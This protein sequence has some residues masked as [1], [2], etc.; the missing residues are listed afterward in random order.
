[1]HARVSRVLL[2]FG[3]VALVST[4]A[5][6]MDWYKSFENKRTGPG[7][8][9][10]DYIQSKYSKILVELDIVGDATPHATALSEFKVEM[11]RALGKAITVQTSQAESGKGAGQAYS[12]A[13]IRA[14][15]DKHRNHFTGDDTAVMYM[16]YLD[17]TNSE[18]G[19]TLGAAYQGSSV[20]MFKGKMKSIT[21]TGGLVATKPDIR[22]VERGVLVHEFGHILGL[23][24][25]GTPMVNGHEDP[26]HPGH[27]NNRNSVMFWAVETGDITQIFTRGSDI[28]Y[29][30]DANDL[31]DIRE[32]RK[33]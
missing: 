18:N 31:A 32:Y 2:A 24:N 10:A 25:L 4:S 1:M 21:S 11:E 33:G 27:S 5:G 14:L 12:F 19:N 6:C 3:I 20:V 22:Y 30:F 7:A 26:D 17:G 9:S 28:P 13:E 16:L 8:Q 29:K 23:V 15:E